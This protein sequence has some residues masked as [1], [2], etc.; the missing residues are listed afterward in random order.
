MLQL[1]FYLIVPAEVLVSEGVKAEVRNGQ[2]DI[3]NKV[4]FDNSS[5]PL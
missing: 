5:I 3:K 2:S 1:I 4:I